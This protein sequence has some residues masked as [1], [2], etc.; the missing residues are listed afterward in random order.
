MI[1]A[2]TISRG[3]PLEQAK[4]LESFEA[5]L[6]QGPRDPGKASG[7]LIEVTAA[8]QE[9]ADDQECPTVT[10]DLRSPRD[11]TILIVWSHASIIARSRE[12]CPVAFLYYMTDV[13]L[14]LRG[15]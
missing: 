8:V 13:P 9:L 12:C 5:P 1:F 2:P 7:K 11:W 15:S 3:A 6:E 14:R 4:S 10:Q